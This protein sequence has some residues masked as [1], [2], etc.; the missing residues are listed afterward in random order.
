MV[1]LNQESSVHSLHQPDS[2]S[3][4][5][6]STNEGTPV[7]PQCQPQM[8]S[9]PSESAVP[10]KCRPPF[11]LELRAGAQCAQ[12]KNH[13]RDVSHGLSSPSAAQEPK[14]GPHG[15]SKGWLVGIN[16]TGFREQHSPSVT[17]GRS[18]EK[19]TSWHLLCGYYGLSPVLS[20]PPAF[21]H[22]TLKVS[23]HARAG[24]G[25]IVQRGKLRPAAARK[26]VHSHEL[27]K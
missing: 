19:A 4:Y 17:G 27:P 20:P 26:L 1:K 18:A 5:T 2:T 14:K 15:H 11:N 13:L 10:G 6:C 16:T 23:P 25:P 3:S 7:S 24:T 8:C 22:F 12:Y 21:T 9:S